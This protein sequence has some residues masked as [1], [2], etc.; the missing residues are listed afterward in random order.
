MLAYAG[1]RVAR[2]AAGRY[3]K[4]L[5]AGITSLFLS[6]ALLNVFTVL[7]LAP[8]T[9]VPLPFISYG[10]TNLI[11]LL[12]GMGLLLNIAAGGNVKLRA[13][14]DARGSSR[15]GPGR[16]NDRHRS[17]RDSGARRAGAGGRRRAA[18]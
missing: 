10:S 13:V 11:V 14:P 16:T 5:A 2:N 1:L 17:G 3:A 8:L 4:L 18:G 12:T 15:H 7:G 9:G 6:Q